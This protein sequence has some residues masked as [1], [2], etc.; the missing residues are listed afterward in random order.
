MDN[1]TLQSPPPVEEHAESIPSALSSVEV[2]VLGPCDRLS[3]RIFRCYLVHI[4]L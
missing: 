3:F 4:Y 2:C 1:A